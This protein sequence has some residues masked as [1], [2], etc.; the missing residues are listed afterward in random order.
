LAAPS[1]DPGFSPKI[2]FKISM[3]AWMV[4]QIGKQ[5]TMEQL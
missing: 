3:V 4:G 2:F 1:G 5:H